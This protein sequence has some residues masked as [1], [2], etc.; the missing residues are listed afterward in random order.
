VYAEWLRDAGAAAPATISGEKRFRRK[1]GSTFRAAVT[2]TPV[3]G[4]EGAPRH[5]VGVV[6]DLT[7]LERA[8]T[9]RAHQRRLLEATQRIAAIGSW[10]WD[11]IADVITWSDEMGRLLGLPPDAEPS[12]E[13]LRD[14]VHP[15]DLERLRDVFVSAF[16][17]G[18]SFV[19]GHRIVRADD[20]TVRDWRTWGE[21]VL[22][23]G[24]PVRFVGTSQ[25]VT[26]AVR[27]E[28]A[29]RESAAL[30]AEAQRIANL[31]SWAWDLAGEHAVWSEW[32]YRLVGR[33]PGGPVPR[34]AE[35]L[36]QI[37]PED[38]GRVAA[39]HDESLATRQRHWK[40][41]FRYILP[42]GE[43]RWFAAE[44]EATY[45]A[46]GR[47]L[48]MVG[49]CRDVTETARATAAAELERRRLQAV[50]DAL[51]VGVVIT[52][53]EG[54]L[55]HVNAALEEIWGGPLPAVE[56]VEGYIEFRAW[57]ADTGRPVEAEEWAVARVL[58]DGGCV[59]GD[60][61]EIERFGDG[62]RGMVLNSA[63]PIVDAEGRT[64]GAVAIMVDL[65][66]RRALEGRLR[67]SQKLEA[68]G[69]LAG[70]VAH[71]FNNLLTVVLSH[72]DLMR[73]E[74][75]PD[76]TGLAADLEEVRQ[77]AQRAADLTRQLLAFSRRQVLRPQVVDVNDVLVQSERLLRRA[78]GERHT[79]ELAPAPSPC[80]VRVDRGQ[81]EQVL[82]NLVLN[83]G[84][85]MPA[86][87]TVTI[88]TAAALVDADAAARAGLPGAGAYVRIAV[89]DT[90]RGMD[91][92]TRARVFEPFFTTK[93]V[94]E[95][96]G[97]GLATAYGIV[98]QSGG[99]FEVASAPGAGT[100]FALYLPRCGPASETA[101]AALGAGGSF[102][103]L[104]RGELILL[105]ED[106]APVR[107][108]A[109]RT[110]ER[111]GFR[112]LE[113]RHGADALLLWREHA[114]EI[115]LVVTDIRM[116]EMGGVELVHH[117]RA[118]RP[119][120]PV[121]Y[122]SGY[123]PGLDATRAAGDARIPFLE[124]PY[125]LTE[126]LEAVRGAMGDVRRET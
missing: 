69:L 82:M 113:A 97:L 31:G 37:H 86:G 116:P 36:T 43:E 56:G 79:L 15:E 74:L 92:A 19:L 88:E 78:L 114:G 112:V 125:T 47:P 38:R 29:L 102:V 126:L 23:G 119:H 61:L 104:G 76:A 33:E 98:S 90:G 20:G 4:P 124:K 28:A 110:L 17:R 11:A 22:E 111:A 9:E 7:E 16:V 41:D 42:S 48:R 89:A 10:E 35:F 122:V 100:T 101:A 118:E 27:A 14:R 93:P 73:D 66:E 68:V 83:A 71:D 1:D 65:S 46:E 117:L 58:R 99:G 13:V 21:V 30:L 105:V 120:L 75:P 60:V 81:L 67:Q 115:A 121:L 2:V 63:A 59:R 53:D 49:T 34:L 40:V 51:P 106:E 109:M 91:E 103:P 25:D 3:P 39:I 70:G 44:S 54:R 87:G 84:D 8:E 57:W 64:T 6:Q 80:P 12:F 26:E 52:D 72:L 108:S 62:G 123:A 85:A 55:T 32:M 18:R 107:R 50:L 94:G 24:R 5:F 77:A 96:T 95:G 45:D